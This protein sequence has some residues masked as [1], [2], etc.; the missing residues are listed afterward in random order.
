MNEVKL[1]QNELFGEVRVLIK[2]G[3]PLF[4]LTDVCSSLG[5]KATNVRQR[6]DQSIVSNNILNDA[7][8]RPHEYS[9]VNEDGLYDVVLD[10]RKPQAKKFRKWV[11]SEIPPSIRK[12][13]KYEI[14]PQYKVPQS[15]SEALR[16][17]ANLQE[18]L[19]NKKNE[20]GQKDNQL[21]EQQ[22]TIDCLKDTNETNRPKV[23]Y[24]DQAMNADG[25]YTITQIA[26]EFNKSAKEFNIMLHNLGIQYN[27]NGQW[28]LYSKYS[29][30]DLTKTKTYMYDKEGRVE[31]RLQTLWTEKGRKFIYELMNKS[32]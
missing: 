27:V 2:N 9:F 20:L 18:E 23:E 22:I 25:L 14:Q 24:Y 4:C 1:F 29:G 15:F 26:K 8:G 30:M 19:E 12:T 3:E 5:L 11:T 6:L 7:N 31:R 16:F 10:S 32:V 28:L 17:A 21:E 13:G